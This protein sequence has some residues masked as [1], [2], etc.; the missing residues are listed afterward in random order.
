MSVNTP[1]VAV[2]CTTSMKVV[3]DNVL[4]GSSTFVWFSRADSRAADLKFWINVGN[5]RLEDFV[6]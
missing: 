6:S 3:R 5:R 4:M 2:R 1:L